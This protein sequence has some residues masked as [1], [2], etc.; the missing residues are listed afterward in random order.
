MICDAALPTYFLLHWAR[1]EDPAKRIE[2]PRAIQ[3]LASD[4]ARS[5]GLDDRGRIAPGMKA[6]VNVIDW[7]RLHLHAPHPV[8]DLPAGG[9]RL[10]QSA[11]GYEVT[12]VS[13]EITYRNGKPTGALPGR[14]V[15]GKRDVAMAA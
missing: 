2:L 7:N 11:D 8:F 12:I 1:H 13:G 3:M 15:R 6:D 4:T 5:V 14:L 9:R 10:V